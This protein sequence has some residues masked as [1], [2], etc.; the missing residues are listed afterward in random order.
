MEGDIVPPN[1][2]VILECNTANDATKNRLLPLAEYS[3][4]QSVLDEYK[5]N[6]LLGY[7]HVVSRNG[8]TGENAVFKEVD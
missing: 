5:K 3:I 4:E 6:V 7:N 2:A 8:Y 1:M